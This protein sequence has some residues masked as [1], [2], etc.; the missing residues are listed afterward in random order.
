MGE[1]KAI[2]E[3]CLE[4]ANHRDSARPLASS[5]SRRERRAPASVLRL[6]VPSASPAEAVG[7]SNHSSGLR[8]RPQPRLYSVAEPSAGARAGA[9]PL[10]RLLWAGVWPRRFLRRPSENSCRRPPGPEVSGP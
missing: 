4:P 10:R 5:Q 8:L 7:C 1:V 3:G 9:L 2:S 6:L